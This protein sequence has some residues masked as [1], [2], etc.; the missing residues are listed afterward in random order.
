M[1]AK[2]KADA[3]KTSIVNAIFDYIE[4]DQLFRMSQQMTSNKMSFKAEDGSYYTV[5]ITKHKSKPDGF[6]DEG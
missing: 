6:K 3:V 1:K 4:G 5:A 2:K